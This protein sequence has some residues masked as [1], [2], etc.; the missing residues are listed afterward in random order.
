[1]K[2]YPGELQIDV[3]ERSA[4]ALWQ[5]DG[6]LSVIADDGRCWSH[7][8]RA[9]HR[10]AAGGRQGA[11]T[12]AKDF[13][14]LLDR[15]PQVRSATKAAIFVGERRWNLRLKDGLDVRCRKTRSATR[16]RR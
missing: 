15:Y 7:L 10:A 1:L 9:V 12:R 3:T 13:L 11:A 4:F 6:R 14:A 8:C 16:W 5:Q 2:L